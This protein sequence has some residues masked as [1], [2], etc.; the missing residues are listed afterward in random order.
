MG[1]FQIHSYYSSLS[2][3]DLK[4]LTD[5]EVDIDRGKGSITMISPTAQ[6]D[7]SIHIG[8]I[9]N[10]SYDEKNGFISM[11]VRARPRRA[12]QMIL[13]TKVAL[14]AKSIA[15]SIRSNTKWVMLGSTYGLGYGSC[16]ESV[17]IIVNL[18]TAPL[19]TGI[20]QRWKISCSHTTNAVNEPST[21][22]RI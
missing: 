1:I 3:K 20:I 14:D 18:C 6:L 16:F 4:D 2:G 9:A 21:R 19:R 22:K 10:I 8:D 11:W 15:Y 5:C 12:Y 7:K 13:R 17:R